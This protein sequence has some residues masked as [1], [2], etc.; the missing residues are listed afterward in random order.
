MAT[1]S[2][3]RTASKRGAK[4]M[5][6]RVD[7]NNAKI[8]AF[9]LL[10]LLLAG[11]GVNYFLHGRDTCMDLLR[12][13][14][15]LGPLAWQPAGCMMHKYSHIDSQ[16]CFQ[17]QHVVFIGDSR[18]RQL[19]F[20]FTSRI[21]SDTLQQGKFHEDLLHIDANTKSHSEFLWHP[22]VNNSLIKAYTNNILSAS[23]KPVLVVLGD[24]T[25][26]IKLN[27]GAHKAFEQYTVNLTQLRP[28]LQRTT[29]ETKIVWMMQAPVQEHLLVGSRSMITNERVTMYNDAAADILENTKVKLWYSAI[30]TS[31]LSKYD[32]TD[33]LHMSDETL[34]TDADL[35][36]NLVCNAK[37]KPSA[38][39]C[40]AGTDFTPNMLQI[41]ALCFFALCGI[42]SLGLK[43]RLRHIAT[44]PPQEL[45]SIPGDQ[46]H[47]HEGSNTRDPELG[48]KHR[49]VDDL[50]ILEAYK[51]TS[52]L[53]KF[54]VILLYFF[55]ADRT[56]LLPKEQK[57]YTNK[58]FFVPL[59][60]II[61][62]G[63]FFVE[64]VPTPSV[65]N[66]PQTTEWKGWMQLIILVYHITGASKKIPIYM[67]V[68]VLV[69]CYLFLTAYGQFTAS[70]DRQKF[71]LVRVCQVL[72]RQNF[73]VVL[74]CIVMNRPYQAYYFVPLISFW[75]LIIYATMASPPRVT[76]ESAEAK[77]SHIIFMLMKLGGLLALCVVL[78][79]SEIF[80]NSLF[81]WWPINTLFYWPG[82]SLYEWWFRW[83]LDRYI[84]VYGMLFAMGYIHLRIT[85]RLKDTLP[86]NL[87]STS[88]TV[89]SVIVGA[90]FIA[91]Y[92]VHSFLCY[93]KPDCNEVHTYISA[94]P[95]TGIIILR[96]SSGYVRARYSTFFAWFGSISLELFISQYHIW[97]AEDTRGILV[98]IPGHPSLNLLVSTFIFI[99]MAH[100]ISRLTGIITKSVISDD[101]TTTRNRALFFCVILG[102]LLAYSTFS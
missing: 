60:Y 98:L 21:T 61:I 30:K 85:K 24:A 11:H 82:Q 74:L 50:Y 66:I 45:V 12:D 63:L 36:L 8:V 15:Y 67:H 52:S 49:K 20:T 32:T 6:D 46:L 58:G 72:F 92:T 97:L 56:D 88:W 42:V 48:F 16:K 65:L 23:K 40:C 43:V 41:I 70:W 37:I 28:E 47:N 86:E 33:G 80:F 31:N 19:Y 29:E 3:G 62:L 76:R 5:P 18:M 26:T 79:M 90:L 87:F 13:G 14:R 35:L 22:E 94:L 75:F 39:T 78:S 34:E 91:I 55:L 44:T 83:R 73:L 64:K 68:R 53:A 95:V 25:W 9:C 77:S 4:E 89:V 51:L 84:L 96:N 27:N 54:G 2:P 69:A 17:D 100:E 71:G 102:A 101:Y 59:V 93:S 1:A 38:T 99:F 57:Y 10:L 81:K 7:E